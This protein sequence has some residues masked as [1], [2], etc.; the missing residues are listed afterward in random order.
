MSY[1]REISEAEKLVATW[2][3]D[4]GVSFCR[5]F[6]SV[7]RLSE[8]QYLILLG[9]YYFESAETDDLASYILS[10][11]HLLGSEA[12][13]CLLDMVRLAHETDEDL[14]KRVNADSRLVLLCQILL[15][16]EHNVRAT[17]I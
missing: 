1:I 10:H 4:A 14:L 16:E 11:V 5:S 7:Y 13:S 15:A 9:Q 6:R 8:L 3:G 12:T 2:Y 17:S